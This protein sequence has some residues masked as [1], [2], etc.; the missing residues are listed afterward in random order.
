M[1][2]DLENLAIDKE[3]A[4]AS[5]A[6]AILA[7]RKFPDGLPAYRGCLLMLAEQ[8]K[9]EGNQ[10]RHNLFMMALDYADDMIDFYQSNP[11]M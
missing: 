4:D 9:A 7:L 1:L 10:R 2:H 8:A 5:L 11:A 6:A 3:V